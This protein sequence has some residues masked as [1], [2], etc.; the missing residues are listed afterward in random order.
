MALKDKAARAAYN[1][2]YRARR[3]ATLSDGEKL[4]LRER[5]NSKQREYCAQGYNKSALSAD[6]Q[7]LREPKGIAARAAS[8]RWD[9]LRQAGRDARRWEAVR[10]ARD[11]ELRLLS[12]VWFPR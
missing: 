6:R 4:A 8:L 2:A 11:D 3:A 10:D 9:Q 5:H 12:E 7:R 1:K